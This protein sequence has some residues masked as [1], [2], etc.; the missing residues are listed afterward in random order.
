MRFISFLSEWCIGTALRTWRHLVQFWACCPILM[1][2]YDF[3]I[4]LRLWDHCTI[5]RLLYGFEFI[6]RFSINCTIVRLC[7]ISILLSNSDFCF[8]FEFVVHLW[9]YC[10]ILETL[11]TLRDGLA[12]SFR[13]TSRFSEWQTCG[14]WNSKICIWE[15]YRD[16]FELPGNEFDDVQLRAPSECWTSCALGKYWRCCFNQSH[17]TLPAPTLVILHVGMKSITIGFVST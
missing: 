13:E 14:L 11:Q 2:L 16:S 17:I 4:V 12:N 15:A 6:S 10:S 7:T 8:E 3:E 9:T 5:L 1:V